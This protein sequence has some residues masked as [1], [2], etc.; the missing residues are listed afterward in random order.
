MEYYNNADSFE[1]ATPIHF[2]VGQ[3]IDIQDIQLALNSRITGT[4]TFL[5]GGYSDR[6]VWI[7]YYRQADSRNFVRSDVPFEV[8]TTTGQ[9]EIL[10]LTPGTYR[11]GV[12]T[13][14]EW[15]KPLAG[16]YNKDYI[17]TSIEDATDIVLGRSQTVPNINFVLGANDYEGTI[18][19]KAL[20]NGVPQP[21]IQVSLYRGS[22]FY[23]LSLT[24]DDNGTYR[25]DDLRNG[26]YQVKFSDPTDQLAPVFY[27]QTPFLSQSTVLTISGKS[28]YSDINVAMMAA[29]QISGLLRLYNNEVL[30]NAAVQVYLLGTDGSENIVSTLATDALGNFVARGLTSGSYRLYFTHPR[31]LIGTVPYGTYNPETNQYD[32]LDIIVTSGQ[33]T[34]LMMVIAAPTASG[35]TTEP[36]SS[37][38]LL[39]F[40]SR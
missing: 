36:L 40:V 12:N 3:N 11:V 23:P 13:Y 9:Y 1:L 38:I 31:I 8:D 10:G 18:Q 20:A 15:D 24:T 30:N 35:E 32:P 21:G 5:G 25:I 6:Y 29:G 17:A 34:P 27:G 26:V 19:G 22:Y 39:P 4:V 28:V 14:R 33:S 7:E 2:T 16:W 37:R